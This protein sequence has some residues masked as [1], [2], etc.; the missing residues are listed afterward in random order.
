MLTQAQSTLGSICSAR[1]TSSAL[2]QHQNG[3]EYDRKHLFSIFSNR[4]KE[5]KIIIARSYLNVYLLEGVPTPE[6]LR[7]SDRLIRQRAC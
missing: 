5:A 1:S 6:R 3:N 4:L 7:M 2:N